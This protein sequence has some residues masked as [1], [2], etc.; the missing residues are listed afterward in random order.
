M[1]V[2]GVSPSDLGMY[3]CVCVCTYTIYTC[4]YTHMLL[5]E[6]SQTEKGMDIT[7]MWNLKN[8]ANA[9]ENSLEI[10]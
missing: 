2:S 6:V 7:Y 5:S 8:S 1:S 10:P 9:M 3:I 4:I